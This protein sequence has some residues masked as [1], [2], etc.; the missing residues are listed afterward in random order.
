MLIPLV[1]L[2][3]LISKAACDPTTIKDDR[4]LEFSLR[5]FSNP[6]HELKSGFAL[7]PLSQVHPKLHFTTWHHDAGKLTAQIPDLDKAIASPSLNHRCSR[8][9]CQV[10]TAKGCL[11]A[12]TTGF[13]SIEECSSGYH[14]QLWRYVPDNKT[15]H[16]CSGHV[17]AWHPYTVTVN[18][19]DLFIS[20]VANIYAQTSGELHL[21]ACLNWLMDLNLQWTG[22]MQQ[23]I[24]IINQDSPHWSGDNATYNDIAILLASLKASAVKH[25]LDRLKLGALFVGW[26]WIYN[27]QKGPFWQRHPE[28]RI[29]RLLNFGRPNLTA[30]T[31]AYASQPHGVPP[32]QS[33][34]E[35][36]ALQWAAFSTSFGLSSVVVRDGFSTYGNYGRYGPFG[37]KA[38][39]TMAVNQVWIDGVRSVFRLLKTHS[40]S[41][42]VIGYSQAS[43]AIGEWM[44]GLTDLEAIVADGYMDAWIDQSWAGAWQDVTVRKSLALGWTYQHAYILAH[45][46]Q[47]VRGNRVRAS[48][49]ESACK[50]YV[51][52]GTFDAYED[53]ST[54]NTAPGKLRW[55]AWA[56]NLA[57]YR[58][59]T[60]RLTSDGQYVSWANSWS[61]VSSGHYVS[62]PIGVLTGSESRFLSSNLNQAVGQ[63]AWWTSASDVLL[64][65][66]LHAMRL[67]WQ[68]QPSLN[69][70]FWVDEQVGMLLKFGLNVNAVILAEDLPAF[71]QSSQA[72]PASIIAAGFTND[73]DAEIV[74]ALIELGKSMRVLVTGRADILHPSLASAVGIL[75]VNGCDD[76]TD[77][78][79]YVLRSSA[80]NGTTTAVLAGLCSVQATTDSIRVTVVNS[81]TPTFIALQTGTLLWAHFNDWLVPK[82]PDVSFV[83]L[84]NSSLFAYVAQWLRPARSIAYM[85]SS[86]QSI[87]QE[88]AMSVLSWQATPQGRAM[89]GATSMTLLGNLETLNCHGDC[90]VLSSLGPREVNVS[91]NSSLAFAL[92]GQ[93]GDL[94]P[95]VVDASHQFVLQDKQGTSLLERELSALSI[96]E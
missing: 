94:L 89:S 45:R 93:D 96:A 21:I 62:N 38:N 40:P 37:A 74:A 80:W 75:H 53:W 69:Y 34:F 24:G 11:V 20:S 9:G 65:V 17:L 3:I 95:Q 76:T 12:S 18:E 5:A 8:S 82:T 41:T 48:K 59:A 58:N 92:V 73:T 26:P 30:D 6:S 47:I 10:E 67:A 1:S 33:L 70:N 25:G 36:F 15:I 50:H 42:T 90:S 84:G 85:P 46:A 83:N 35:L 32:G 86:Q 29:G 49:G 28:V 68:R 57:A 16:H 44:I 14:Q 60:H 13:V 22:D 77:P 43:S 91:V 72:R 7:L 87:T 23:P 81:S 4:L 2:F 27:I 56:W 63:K 88:Q 66:D 52:H 61:Q 55:G 64:V 19:T 54:I 31:Y 78:Q 79:P 71:V 51:L 39:A